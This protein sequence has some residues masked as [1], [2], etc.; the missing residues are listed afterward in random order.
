MA[1]QIRLKDHVKIITNHFE[2]PICEE[3]DEE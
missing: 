2:C 1:K 3:D